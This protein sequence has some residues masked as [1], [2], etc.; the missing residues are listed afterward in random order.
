MKGYRNW[1]FTDEMGTPVVYVFMNRWTRV[2]FLET[3]YLIGW[4]L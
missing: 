3:P 2:T 1:M 4:L